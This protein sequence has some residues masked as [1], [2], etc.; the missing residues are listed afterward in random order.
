MGQEDRPLDPLACRA[1]GSAN[2]VFLAISLVFRIFA[3]SNITPLK[4][5]NPCPTT[6]IP[7]IKYMKSIDP[8]IRQM[9]KIQY[10]GIC[11]I[12]SDNKFTRKARYL[13]IIRR[14]ESNAESGWI[15]K[16]GKKVCYANLAADGKEVNRNFLSE[17]IFQYAKKRVAE[18]Q[19]YETIEE[20]RLFCNFLSS[21]PMAFNLFYPLM[22]IIKDNA[23]KQ[24]LLAN[25]VKILLKGEKVQQIDKI[26]EVGIEYIPS[27]WEDCLHDKTAMDAYFRYS[28]IEGRKGIIAIETKY[29]DK[30]GSNEASNITPALEAVNELKEVFTE[31][32]LTEINKRN[33]KITQIVRNFLLTEKVR[34]KESLDDSLSIVL[35]PEGNTSNKTDERNFSLLL[36]PEY[37]YKFQTVT[38][39]DF[40]MAIKY[41]FPDEPIFEAFFKRYLEFGLVDLYGMK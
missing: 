34:I 19:K 25:V 21:Q 4:P 18:K 28:T 17:D 3:K 31:N 37:Q 9:L 7:I 6:I 10:G 35:A 8:M 2:E 1:G 38:L 14:Y 32:G 27:Y 36:R 11:Y 5:C 23:G 41:T 29:T 13:Q 40:V 15:I 26:T 30:L 33:I 24:K 22:Q 16:D 20:D 12:E 39:E